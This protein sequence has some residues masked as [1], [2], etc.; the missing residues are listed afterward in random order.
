MIPNNKS[1]G[2]EEQV[3]DRTSNGGD[4]PI[5]NR[6][7]ILKSMGVFGAGSALI[8]LGSGNATSSE[9][10]QDQCTSGD[11]NS[12]ATYDQES[13]RIGIINDTH[14]RK[15]RRAEDIPKFS[16]Q[17]AEYQQFV[18]AMNK[19]VK[20]DF[21]VHQGDLADGWTENGDDVAAVSTIAQRIRRLKEI[22]H[23]KL[24]MPVYN[25][26]GNHAYHNGDKN[27]SEIYRAVNSDW[28][29]TSDTWYS[30]TN[31]GYEFIFLNTAYS[32][33]PQP[34]FYDHTAP[35]EEVEWLRDKL[36]ETAERP[37]FVFTHVPIPPGCGGRYDQFV[38]QG[39][40]RDILANSS[41]FV[42][43]FFA[44]SHHC[45]EWDRL[46]EQQDEAGNQY[47]HNTQ[48]HQWMDDRSQVPWSVLQ[49]EDDGASAKRL[50]FTAGEGVENPG[51][52]QTQWSQRFE[53]TE[54][55]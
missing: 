20:P 54:E 6:R 34:Y 55:P 42:A 26:M 21:V 51:G 36:E 40:I 53:Y 38:H 14:M 49:I 8:G 16:V 3:D 43:G 9:Q 13:L 24:D 32:D 5:G 22:L 17:R 28:S 46:R 47:Y 2:E 27:I 52:Y 31:G 12:N 7:S 41:N 37:A 25:I 48:P 50:Q 4:F 1:Q 10:T 45:E 39:H 18:D 29:E 11:Q 33:T 30:I 15:T 35:V 44:H 19:R 23:E